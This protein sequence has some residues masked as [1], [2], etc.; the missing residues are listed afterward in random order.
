MILQNSLKKCIL[1]LTILFVMSIGA[2]AQKGV[3]VQTQK[4]KDEGNKAVNPT[5]NNTNLL[6]WGK[7]KTKTLPPIPNPYKLTARRDVLMNNIVDVLREKKMIVD[8]RSSRIKD[9]I[10]VTQPCVFAKGAV[11][12][13][14]ELSQYAVLESSASAWT[15]A[16]Y[17]LTIEVQSID[18]IQ[19]NV[20]ATAKVEGRAGNGLM[21][22]W[23]T[24][25]SSGLAEHKFL[26]KLITLVTGVSPDPAED[27][28]EDAVKPPC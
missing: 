16:Q 18:G 23:V 11:I 17:T 9:G 15:R 26:A 1:L 3:D 4:I 6:N 10:I 27:K 2:Y 13:Q 7:D 14:S 5:S 12:T 20:S 24:L 21:S 25:Q 19:N 22:E 8:D 28:A